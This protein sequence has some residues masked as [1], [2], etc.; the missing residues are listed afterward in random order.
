ML[1]AYLK[2][3]YPSAKNFVDA[4]Q[5]TGLSQKVSSIAFGSDWLLSLHYKSSLKKRFNDSCS[6]C[7]RLYLK[8]FLTLCAS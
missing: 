1:L 5:D 6:F 7:G 2:K 4:A 8:L 3:K